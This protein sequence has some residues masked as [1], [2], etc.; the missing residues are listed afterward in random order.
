MKGV[1][2]V[3]ICP[4]CGNK[5]GMPYEDSQLTGILCLNPECGRFQPFSKEESV[6]VKGFHYES[7]F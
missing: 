1:F 4:F 3:W 5:D 6:G 2:S 7:D